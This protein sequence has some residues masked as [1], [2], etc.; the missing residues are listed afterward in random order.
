MRRTMCA[1]IMLFTVGS[2]MLYFGVQVL[3]T[4]RDRALGMIVTGAIAFLPG[5]YA[6]WTILGAYMGW[7]GYDMA[8]LPSYD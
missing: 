2:L 1:A 5:L 3:S 8:A 6:C 7:R 4:E